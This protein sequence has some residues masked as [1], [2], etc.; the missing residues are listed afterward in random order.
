[1]R[2]N[3]AACSSRSS[4]WSYGKLSQTVGCCRGFLQDV[5]RQYRDVPYHNYIHA[6]DVLS[7]CMYFMFED[8]PE[9]PNLLQGRPHC[10]GYSED[11]ASLSL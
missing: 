2:S 9:T 4:P 10:Y 3:A 6:V 11:T 5:Q 1:M 7:S 8:L